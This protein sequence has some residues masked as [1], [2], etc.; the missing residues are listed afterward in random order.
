ME[1]NKDPINVDQIDLANDLLD[2]K[3]IEN[4]FNKSLAE[5]GDRRKVLRDLKEALSPLA[6]SVRH[7]SG[8]GGRA[9]D[10]VY[11]AERELAEKLGMLSD[12]PPAELLETFQGMESDAV[13]KIKDFQEKLY[14]HRQR[15]GRSRDTIVS[16]SE[17]N[18]LPMIASSGKTAQDLY[19]IDYAIA[20]SDKM[21]D[22]INTLEQERELKI[23]TM[24]D[25]SQTG[26]EQNPDR[27]YRVGGMGPGEGATYY[28]LETV[29]KEVLAY[30]STG[31]DGAYDGMLTDADTGDSIGITPFTSPRE[32]LRNRWDSSIFFLTHENFQTT[33]SKFYRGLAP[34]K[35]HRQLLAGSTLPDELREGK[36]N[37]D[38]GKPPFEGKTVAE[39]PNDIPTYIYDGLAERLRLMQ[40]FNPLYKQMNNP[41]LKQYW[42][43]NPKYKRVRDG[44]NSGLLHEHLTI[45]SILGDPTVHRAVGAAYPSRGAHVGRILLDSD[46]VRKFAE[47]PEPPP[48]EFLVD[49]VPPYYQFMLEFTE[50]IF[51][52][53]QTVLSEDSPAIKIGDDYLRAIIY[54]SNL[55]NV[56]GASILAV[57]EDEGGLIS[58]LPF[59]YTGASSKAILNLSQTL[60]M[61]G[62]LPDEAV[63]D[64]TEW[65]KEFIGVGEDADTERWI[66]A[67]DTVLAVYGLTELVNAMTK[68]NR[69]KKGMLGDNHPD[70]AGLYHFPER[71][72][73][74]TERNANRLAIL[75][76]WLLTY[77]TAKGIVL[78]EKPVSRAERRR[79]ERAQEKGE[80][81]PEP[82]HIVNVEPRTAYWTG[83]NSGE[84]GESYGKHSYRYIVRG[85]LRLGKHKLK[86]GSY[87]RTREWIKPHERGLA[88]TTF[89]PNISSYKGDMDE[90]FIPDMMEVD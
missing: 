79:T 46:Q 17:T 14:E 82:W 90:K 15:L 50:P 33:R 56:P 32:H 80:S 58:Y 25:D 87:R 47:A 51:F 30:D 36:K 68:D 62:C 66:P 89:I 53:E 10:L 37:R 88:N 40:E 54:A 31:K 86:D 76:S 29:S 5:L 4:G 55:H 45:G 44:L 35:A 13:H 39:D 69:S 16:A 24:E 19:T 83:R 77:M 67:C 73:G 60:H 8:Q 3:R 27:T 26:G 23:T 11:H 64:N 42:D 41:R 6:D 49:L 65:P 7:S 1:D 84:K 38:Q 9:E 72:Y 59:R 57:F 22:A 78:E 20:M 12:I 2:L 70:A 52:G 43:A 28:E 34:I 71:H 21:M 74:T 48:K 18:S 75:V 81:L 63:N 61:P 85:H